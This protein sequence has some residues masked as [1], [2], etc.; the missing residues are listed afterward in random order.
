[1]HPMIPAEL[2]VTSDDL[3]SLGT[4]PGTTLVVGGGYIAVEC[5]GFLRGIGKEVYL[6]N[7]SS[8]LRAMDSDMSERIVEELQEEGVKTLTKTNIVDAKAVEGGRKEVTLKVGEETKTIT[9]DTIL[10]AIG[11]DS[12]PAG[13]G[14]DNA[15]VNYTKFGKIVG[16]DEEPERTSV[17][18]IYA[19]GDI[20]LGVPELMPVA[21]KSGKL[22]AQ[23]IYHRL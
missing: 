2:S 12:N 9:V 6:A 7:R 8:F 23:R 3:F 13:L 10:V 22:L 17:D 19:V 11:R 14:A 20:V 5:A 21:Q 15:G 16:R 18:N 4:D 1:L